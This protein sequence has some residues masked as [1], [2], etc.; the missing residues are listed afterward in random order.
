MALVKVTA[1]FLC[2]LS[3]SFLIVDYYLCYLFYRKLVVAGFWLINLLELVYA[4]A[5]PHG[6][7]K[8]CFE[9][10]STM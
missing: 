1:D 4:Y 5:Q 8:N 7:Q 10:M 9:K 6:A 3:F 2:A